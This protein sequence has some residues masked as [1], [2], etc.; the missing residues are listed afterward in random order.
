MK[1]VIM[2]FFDS[3]D[4]C[5]AYQ[6][7]VESIRVGVAR[8]FTTEE[9]RDRAV[10]AILNAIEE[11]CCGLMQEVADGTATPGDEEHFQHIDRFCE[12]IEADQAFELVAR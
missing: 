2:I 6:N 9:G 12:A 7:I 5:A 1:E 10:G 11:S 3:S 8:T 4:D